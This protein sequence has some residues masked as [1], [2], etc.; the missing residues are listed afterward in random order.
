MEITHPFHP[1]RGQR[2]RVLRERRLA[3][4][5][6]LTLRGT[7]EGTFAIPLSWTDAVVDT[8]LRPSGV[9]PPCLDLGCL[10]ELVELIERIRREE[11]NAPT[12]EG[13]SA[14]VRNLNR[15]EPLT[16]P[17]VRSKRRT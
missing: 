14:T 2:F 10:L 6:T 9:H 12:P 1:L 17:A 3:G 13:Y 15:R 4:I 8:R 7:A 5:H 11:K 16:P